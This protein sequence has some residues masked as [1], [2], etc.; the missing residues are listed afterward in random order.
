[1]TYVL[2]I[3]VGTSACKAALVDETGRVAASAGAAYPVHTPRTG[4]AEQDPDDWWRGVCAAVRDV[5]QTAAVDPRHIA[6]VGVDGQS[7][8]AVAVDRDGNALGPTPIW[9]DT[10]AEDVCAEWRETVG[11]Q[12]V[13]AV[14][15]NP[16][17]PSY[18]APKVAWYK[19]HLPDLYGKAQKILQSN[20]YIVL[21]LTGV[22][23]QD[24]SQ[25]YGWHCFDLKTCAWDAALC[26]ALGLDPDLLP[27]VADCHAVVGTVTP[28]AAALSGLAEGTPVVAGGLDAACG[29]LGAGVIDPGQTQEQGGQ[30]GGMSICCADA[31]TDI[32]LITSPHVVPGRWLLQGGTTGGGGVMRWLE[33]E[34]GAAERDRARQTGKSVFA[35]LDEAAAAVPPGSDGVVFLPYMAGE[36]SPLWDPDARAL[37]YGMDVRTTKGHLIRA[38]LEG[39]AFALRHNLEVAEEAGAPV[40]V[41]RAVGGAA[42]SPLWTQIKADVTGKPL[43]IPDAETATA[44]GAAILA[45]VG[46]GVFAD[47]ADAVAKCVTVR[48]TVTPD[49]AHKAVYDERYALYRRLYP[50]YQILERKQQ[51]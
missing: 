1:M 46:A 13:F 22:C 40:S 26:R 4:W 11:E 43:E 38:A 47:F 28:S 25:G 10:R 16:L 50:A 9:M 37:F 21:K 14:C 51:P 44:M 39:V 48:R 29:T 30:A 32:R 18:T 5:L 33:R 34:F 6:A 24:K 42:N 23:S 3:D 17:K 12:A 8:S 31:K 7:W 20:G 27:D 15:G 35:L 45:G 19:R 2:G 41:L 49:P 36:R